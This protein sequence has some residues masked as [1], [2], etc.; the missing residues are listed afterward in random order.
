MDAQV[1]AI[2]LDCWQAKPLATGGDRRARDAEHLGGLSV[3]Q[4]ANDV[5]DLWPLVLDTWSTATHG[6][7][8][9]K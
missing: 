5:G 2:D 1:Q 6:A 4:D 7:P 9:A 8:V 3:W